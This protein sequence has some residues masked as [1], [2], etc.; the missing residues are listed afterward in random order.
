MGNK[1]RVFVFIDFANL[2]SAE[3]AKNQKLDMRKLKSYIKE[4]T[5]ADEI[6]VFYYTAYPAEGT[7]RTSTKRLHAYYHF[8][9]KELNF[10][11]RKKPLKRLS[12]WQ[13]GEEEIK[14]KG[15]LDVEL[16]MD[17]VKHIDDY[18]IAVLF[19]GDSD[20]KALVSFMKGRQKTVFVYSTARNISVELR[21]SAHRYTDVLKIS[22]DIWKNDSAK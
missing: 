5:D 19:T 4:R 13:N 9:N 2:H 22:E 16:T 12:S 21:S 1:R 14:E 15:N 7:R 11:V 20:F 8:L 6:S 17:A 10:T 18:D 3:L